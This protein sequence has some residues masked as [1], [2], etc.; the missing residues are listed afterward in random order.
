MRPISLQSLKYGGKKAL[1]CITGVVCG[2]LGSASILLLTKPTKIIKGVKIC[3]SVCS[4]GL[5]V[6]VL[7]ASDPI[8]IVEIAIFGRPVVLKKSQEFDLFSDDG[9]DP[10]SDTEKIVIQIF[11]KN[12]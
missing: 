4:C 12:K 8:N 10:I 2:Y 6:V 5:D 3:H 9:S 1:G 7:C 11:N